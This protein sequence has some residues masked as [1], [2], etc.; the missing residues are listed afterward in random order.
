MFICHFPSL[1]LISTSWSHTGGS[2]WWKFGGKRFVLIIGNISLAQDVQTTLQ[3]AEDAEADDDENDG[4]LRL[5][6]AK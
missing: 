2:C 1:I 4:P 3:E 6:D 5:K